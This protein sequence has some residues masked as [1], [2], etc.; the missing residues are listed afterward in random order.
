MN[1]TGNVLR[2][3]SIR[4]VAA[5]QTVRQTYGFQWTQLSGNGLPAVSNVQNITVSPTVTSRYR[6][7]IVPL[8]GFGTNGGGCGDTTSILVRVAP[9]VANAFTIPRVISSRNG[10][11]GQPSEPGQTDIPPL[12]FVLNNT[13]PQP[14]VASG[15][16]L[17]G[18]SWTYQRVKDGQGN[19]VTDAPV[20]FSTDYQPA[21]AALK[22]AVGGE[23]IIRLNSN[24]VARTSSCAANTPSCP[25]TLAQRTVIVPDVPVP[26]IITPNG[27][28]LNETFVVRPGQQGGK[29]EIYNRWGRKVQDFASYQ[30]NWGGDNQPDGVYYYYLTDV[31]G[32]KTKGWVEIRRGQ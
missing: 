17:C 29:L 21:E 16:Q 28:N 18:I 6:L 24:V 31:S 22:L 9:T 11:A 23:Y 7:R 8:Q 4:Q 26:N 32:S 14:S 13:T 15:F 25:A 2:P 1:L 10:E 12:T 20:Q 5:G 30:N 3:D 19:A 27:D